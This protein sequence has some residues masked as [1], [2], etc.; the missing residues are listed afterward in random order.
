MR[1]FQGRVESMFGKKND[2]ETKT[3]PDA[4]REPSVEI[5]KRA[6]R[7]ETATSSRGPAVPG[8]EPRRPI[9]LGMSAQAR[10]AELRTAGDGPGRGYG[11]AREGRASPE[12]R[13]AEVSSAGDVNTSKLI[14]GRDIILHGEIRACQNLVVEGRVEAAL[15]DCRSIE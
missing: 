8:G 6:F 2:P 13:H 12:S 7:P 3:G 1:P 15:T 11:D 14:V 5:P 4:A 9:D 10:R